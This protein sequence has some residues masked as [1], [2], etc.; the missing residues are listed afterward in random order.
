MCARFGK[1]AATAPATDAKG[2][3]GCPL[4]PAVL[5]DRKKPAPVGVPAFAAC[6]AN[7]TRASFPNDYGLT[8]QPSG[9][10]ALGSA[11]RSLSHEGA[12]LSG[13]VSSAENSLI[14]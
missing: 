9:Y 5:G 2:S 4:E 13:T 1:S 14:G 3:A 7:L 8:L 10:G 12:D 6:R 11:L